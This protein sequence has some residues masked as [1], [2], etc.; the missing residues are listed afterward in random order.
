MSAHTLVCWIADTLK[1]INGSPITIVLI[2]PLCLLFI[3]IGVYLDRLTDFLLILTTAL[4]IDASL[5]SRVT[6]Y[7]VD[8]AD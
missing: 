8:H 5:S 2:L 7:A 3:G 6:T 4:S 1:A